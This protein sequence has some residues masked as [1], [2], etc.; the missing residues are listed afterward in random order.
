MSNQEL[1]YPVVLEAVAKW[2]K[3]EQL[4]LIRE[5]L[6]RLGP[7]EMELSTASPRTPTL[8]KAAGLLKTDRPAPSDEEVEKILLERREEKYG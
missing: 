3:E 2:P 5:I 8:E 4:D 1:T 6:F 7:D